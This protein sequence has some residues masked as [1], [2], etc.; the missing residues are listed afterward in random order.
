MV[1]LLKAPQALAPRVSVIVVAYERRALVGAC[2]QSL[3]L[4]SEAA[5][6]ALVVLNGAAKDIEEDVQHQARLDARIRPL[7]LSRR[8]ASEARN[9]GVKAARA[10][11]LYFLDDDVEVPDHGLAAVLDLFERRKDIAIAGGPNLTPPDDPDFAQMAGELLASAFGTGIAH[12]RYAPGSE[13]PAREKHLTLCNLG[14][15]RAVFESGVQ[16]P[17]VFG[18]EENVLMGKASYLGHRLWYSPDLW[19]HHRRRSN[20]GGHVAQ[21]HRYGFGRGIALCSAPGTFHVAYFVP[22]AFTAYLLVAL[23]AAFLNPL[24]LLP[25]GAY[26]ALALTASARIAVRRRR[27]AW[28]MRLPG[29]FALTHVAYAL[30]LVKGL[31]RGLRTRPEGTPAQQTPE[32]P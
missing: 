23:P 20:V 4:Q 1:G 3:L 16:F 24:F 27:L 15:R 5:F 14:V 2:I 13:R 18:G 32:S 8:S 28:M 17:T 29:L 21:V 22:L 30:G 12:L 26:A 31:F 6:E 9:E 7:N 11:L 10:P 25:A 19:V